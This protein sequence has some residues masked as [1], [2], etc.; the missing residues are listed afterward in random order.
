MPVANKRTSRA[1]VVGFS[2]SHSSHS[3]HSQRLFE[4]LENSELHADLP[5]PQSSPRGRGRKILR[6]F[7]LLLPLGEGW[8]EGKKAQ[9]NVN[10][11]VFKQSLTSLLSFLLFFLRFSHP[12]PSYYYGYA[13]LFVFSLFAVSRPA[14]CWRACCT[15]T[16]AAGMFAVVSWLRKC[17]AATVRSAC[18]LRNPRPDC[19]RAASVRCRDALW[20]ESFS[21]SA[22]L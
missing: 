4:K 21:A 8:D 13:S 18:H 9:E 5:S 15:S 17:F 2:L 12:I 20:A 22:A 3:S 14:F 7:W 11:R 16:R 19:F 1:L 6:C 10:F